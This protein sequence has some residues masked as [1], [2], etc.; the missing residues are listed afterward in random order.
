MSVL[1]PCHD[2]IKDF[3]MN[4]SGRKTILAK[5]SANRE[6]L[7][8]TLKPLTQER[9]DNLQMFIEDRLAEHPCDDSRIAIVIVLAVD[10]GGGYYYTWLDT[11][12][13][14]IEP[15][16]KVG[17][18]IREEADKLSQSVGLPGFSGLIAEL[19]VL[20]RMNNQTAPAFAAFAIHHASLGGMTDKASAIGIIIAEDRVGA[21]VFN[22]D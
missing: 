14:N 9:K 7:T 12:K 17:S 16:K 3:S 13:A 20:G 5:T 2:I 21:F 4:K 8:Q 1:M 15:L 22:T 6:P 10:S 18:F 19:I 11:P